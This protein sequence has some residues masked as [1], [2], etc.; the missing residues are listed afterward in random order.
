[1]VF[2]FTLALCAGHIVGGL[3]VPEDKPQMYCGRSLSV[4]IS[5]LCFLQRHSKRSEGNFLGNDIPPYYIEDYGG[6]WLPP[7]KARGLGFSSRNKRLVRGVVDEC[8]IKACSMEELL[9]YC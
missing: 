9:E 4:A 6:P 7:H 3:M 8:C 2:L 1:M 5:E